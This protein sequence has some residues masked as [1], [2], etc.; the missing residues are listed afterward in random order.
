MN[1]DKNEMK[2]RRAAYLMPNLFTTG[3]VMAGFYSVI[4]SFS[5]NY[6]KACTAIVVAMVLDVFDGLV[7]RMTGTQS[8]FGGEYDSLADVIAFGMAPAVLIYH[9]GLFAYPRI[10]GAIAF[11]YLAA[12]AIRLAR[13]NVS[14]SMGKE[15]IGLPCPAAA[16]L[17]TSFVWVCVEYGYDR[18]SGG[19]LFF[20]SLVTLA[21]A[22]SM[23]SNTRYK[24]LKS[25]EHHGK[26]SFQ[27]QACLIGAIAVVGA[28]ADDLPLLIFLV[29]LIYWFSGFMLSLFS[30]ARRSREARG[31]N[32]GEDFPGG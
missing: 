29:F 9:G 20:G 19:L 18:S 12:T 21:T 16:A 3:V 32:D 27:Y 17:V 30:L 6:D 25:L 2:P 22:L 23:V 10:G 8:S 5:G 1:T 14:K 28:F 11:V 13:F 4:Q 31:V 15:F 26:L 7:A 24:S